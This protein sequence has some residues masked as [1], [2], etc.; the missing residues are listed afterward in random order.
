MLCYSSSTAPN[1]SYNGAELLNYGGDINRKSSSETRASSSPDDAA[2]ASN[3]N[4]LNN[5]L[6]RSRDNRPSSKN[7]RRIAQHNGIVYV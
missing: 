7:K 3:H 5:R 4:T 2:N 1:G 6:R